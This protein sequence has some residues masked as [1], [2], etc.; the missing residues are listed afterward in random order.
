MA[1]TGFRPPGE[2]KTG[3]DLETAGGVEEAAAH[4]CRLG[5]CDVARS[6][7][8]KAL[9]AK[10]A[11]RKHGARD[12]LPLLKPL[13]QIYL[14]LGELK[15]A[16]R[17][18]ER[19]VGL[20]E[21]EFG[22]ESVELAAPLEVLASIYFALGLP[23]KCYHASERALTILQ[24]ALGDDDVDVAIARDRL[25]VALAEIGFYARAR[26][27]HLRALTVLRAHGR[28]REMAATLADAAATY[29]ATGDLE[30]ARPLYEEALATARAAFGDEHVDT[31]TYRALLGDY[32][33]RAG[34]DAQALREY[35][36]ALATKQKTLGELHPDIAHLLFKIGRT[37]YRRDKVRGRET[38]LQA[39]AVL[40]VRLHRPHLFAEICSFLATILPLRPASIFFRKLAVNDIENLR[41]HVARL[42]SILE[43]SF[44]KQN[45]DDFRALGDDLIALGRLPEAQHVLTMIKERELYSLTRIDA[46]RTR[47]PMTRLEGHCVRRGWKL[48]T[49]LYAGLEQERRVQSASSRESLQAAIELAGAA[50]GA[51][52]DRIVAD[53]TD[54]DGQPANQTAQA[55]TPASPA[56]QT[57]APGTALLQYLLM[58]DQ[59]SVSIILTTRDLQREQRVTFAQGELN[60][61]VYATREAL[62]SRSTHFLP[63]AQR[64]YSTLVAPLAPI[65]QT[66]NVHTLALS[67]DGVLRYLPMGALHDGRSYLIEQYALLLATHAA[68]AHGP[69]NRAKLRAAGLGVSRSLDGHRTLSGVRDELMAVIRTAREHDG[70]LPGII[71]LDR[72][73]T[74]EALVQVLSSQYSV[75]HVASHFVFAAARESSSYLLLGDG[76]KLTLAE[77]ADLRFDAMDLVVLSACN[78]AIGGGH[79]QNGHEIEGLGALV[80][81]QGASQVLAT[82]WPVADMTTVSLMRAFYRNCYR[83]GLAP[84]EALRRAQLSLLNGGNEASAAGAERCLVDPD[85]NYSAG[86]GTV[87]T[88]HPFYWAPYILMSGL[89]QA[90]A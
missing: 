36:L 53:F 59:Q 47:V 71:R 70:V 60:K 55:A 83:A 79:H 75:I 78:T 77:F 89:P 1:E 67:L 16:W 74:A 39:I 14:Q 62:Q 88:R 28:T 80:R 72:A 32:W 9:E 5:Q 44:L 10:L 43:R 31:A 81:H 21:A 23:D 84:P 54:N 17:C 27:L 58:P 2:S 49:R 90:P 40:D 4:H 64:L 34:D 82:L 61:L 6:L 19:V 29:L 8:E 63:S 51:E 45:R 3:D 35:R 87:D 46:R 24:T 12:L 13:G 73:F 15:K 41:L 76:S 86:D 68:G 18:F 38:V 57:P 26:D 56:N 69:V 42:D 48:L 30:K 65:L 25:G 11:Q 50:L 85:D 7:L 52:L 22:S 37:E 20:A 33:A 66:S